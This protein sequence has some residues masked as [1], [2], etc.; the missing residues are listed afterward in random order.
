M[1]LI[2]YVTSNNLATDECFAGYKNIL[3]VVDKKYIEKLC[4]TEDKHQGIA[5][6]IG[7]LKEK[8]EL[9]QLLDSLND[10][11]FRYGMILDR[12]QD[13]HN[14][15]AII[16]SA[17]CFAADFII[18]PKSETPSINST[19]IRSSVGYSEVLP[20]YYVVNLAREIAKLKELG[21]WI[22][23]LDNNKSSKLPADV[24]KHYNNKIIFVLGSEGYGIKE[25]TKREC[26]DFIKI[27]MTS[28]AESLNVSNAATIIGYESFIK[29]QYV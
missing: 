29:K 22:I 11:S 3:Q 6:K 15:G 2:I 23:G 1:N 5:M 21:Y 24:I 8:T 27:P 7:E 13:P 28:D 19:I 18:L 25:L 10:Q 12:V 26:D 14:I 16:R 20:I 17:Y 4:K 9:Y